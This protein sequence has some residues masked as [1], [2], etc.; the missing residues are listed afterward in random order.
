MY[1]INAVTLNILRNN[2]IQKVIILY[3]K[4]HTPFTINILI[5]KKSNNDMFS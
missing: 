1:I 4:K 3:I 2:E 5:Y